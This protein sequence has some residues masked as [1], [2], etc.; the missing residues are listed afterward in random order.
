MTQCGQQAEHTL[1]QFV[2]CYLRIQCHDNAFTKNRCPATVYSVLPWECAQRSGAQQ[3]VI[4]LLT[5]VMSQY[6]YYDGLGV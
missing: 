4:F 1:E 5:G 3:T 2:Y 6:W